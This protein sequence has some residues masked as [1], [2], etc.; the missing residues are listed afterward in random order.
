MADLNMFFDQNQ[1]CYR[2][3][4]K[5]SDI[6]TFKIGGCAKLVCFPNSALQVSETVKFCKE[7][8]IKYM[9]FGKCSNVLFPD[10]GLTSLVIKTDNLEQIELNDGIFCFGSGVMLAKASKFTISNGYKGMEF[11]YGIPG[12]V[13]GAV[14]MNA[15]AYGGEMSQCVFKTE[16]V[17]ENGE[18]CVLEKEK[19]DFGYRHTFFSDTRYIITKSY[20]KLEKGDQSESEQLVTQYQN[21]RK[22]KQP[23]DMPSAGSVFK[24][25]EGNFAGKLIEDS[26]LMGASVGGAAVSCK[27]AGFIVNTGDAT[28]ADVK[29]LIEF[30]QNNVFDKFGVE[31]ECELRCIE[32]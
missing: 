9:P 30:I 4:V 14:F 11:A 19:H 15:G 1:I 27:H 23:L 6:S 5:L 25:P 7:H 8:A 28:A 12:S 20:I 32:D 10:D 2:E 29:S 24:R 16:Y 13:G 21:S 31:L 17:D 26:G 22:S 3:N 18:I